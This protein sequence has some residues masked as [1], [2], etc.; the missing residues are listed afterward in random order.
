LN[1]RASQ[2]RLERLVLA[3]AR[4]LSASLNAHREHLRYYKG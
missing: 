2:K 1:E 4:G 3:H